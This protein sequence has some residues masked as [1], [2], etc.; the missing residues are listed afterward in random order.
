MKLGNCAFINSGIDTTGNLVIFSVKDPPG[1]QVASTR[2]AC[3][4]LEVKKVLLV[5]TK[6]C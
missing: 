1:S 5:S 4:L 2:G 3:H 6:G